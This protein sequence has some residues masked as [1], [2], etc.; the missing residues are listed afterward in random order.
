MSRYLAAEAAGTVATLGAVWAA[1]RAGASA[2]IAGQCGSAAETVAYYGVILAL[3]WRRSGRPTLR[4]LRDLL[5]EFGPAELLD[6]FVTRPLLLAAGP[7]LI[8][9]V[10]LGALAGKVV[11]DILFYVVVMP[12]R[13]LHH[14][15]WPRRA[16]TRAAS[17]SV[18]ARSAGQADVR[19]FVS[20][21][22]EG[23]AADP[24][25]LRLLWPE[26]PARATADPDPGGAPVPGGSPTATSRA[27]DR[28]P[29]TPPG[30]REQ[31]G[32]GHPSQ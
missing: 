29:A 30:D 1:H 11:A 13:S 2:F 14:Q 8:G 15:L 10:A 28:R 31:H 16:R 17:A 25:D 26:D 22:S 18:R 27:A 3:E 12:S 9:D 32:E 6:T 7:E 5:I 24:V 4:S 19:R 23:L 20:G 21:R